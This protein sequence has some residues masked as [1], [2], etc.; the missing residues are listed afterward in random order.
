MNKVNEMDNNSQ[1]FVE[2]VKKSGYK[3]AEI[4]EDV[5][6]GEVDMNESAIL[7]MTRTG[8]DKT[9]MLKLVNLIVMIS[10]SLST[11]EAIYNKVTVNKDSNTAGENRTDT[12]LKV[13][14][15]Y[16]RI[17]A[18]QGE[19]G[20]ETSELTALVGSILDGEIDAGTETNSESAS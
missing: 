8:T 2:L 7:S 16:R 18:L 20:L 6:N 12:H 3:L 13:V 19:L 15:I 4:M 17:I 5:L 14:S 1:K 11:Y 9:K 10:K